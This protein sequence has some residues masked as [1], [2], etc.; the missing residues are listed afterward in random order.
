MIKEIQ[1]HRPLPEGVYIASSAIHGMGLFTQK[2]IKSGYDFGITH[3]ADD[4]FPDGYIRT[5]FGA[6]INHSYTPNCEVVEVED[7][8]HIRTI[9]DIKAEEELTLNYAPYYTEDELAN[10]N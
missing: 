2:P 10:Y 4:R 8:L 3:V 6:F 7:T 9:K 5:P 1:G